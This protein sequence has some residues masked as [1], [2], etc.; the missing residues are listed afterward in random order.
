MIWKFISVDLT[1]TTN[2]RSTGRM[3]CETKQ[4]QRSKGNPR[5]QEHPQRQSR[6]LPYNAFGERHSGHQGA[7]A[8]ERERSTDFHLTSAT[9]VMFA[10]GKCSVSCARYVAIVTGQC[11]GS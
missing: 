3:R 5:T 9:V 4:L 6:R 8:A 2:G 10:K 7:M 11:A 1:A